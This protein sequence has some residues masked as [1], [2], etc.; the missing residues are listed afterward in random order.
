MRLQVKVPSAASSTQLQLL[1]TDKPN[2]YLSPAMK[3]ARHK[4]LAIIDAA[5]TKVPTVVAL[6]CSMQTTCPV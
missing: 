4:Y 1:G 6:A 3:E 5:T 2:V